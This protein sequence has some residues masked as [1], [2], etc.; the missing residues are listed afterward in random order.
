MADTTTTNLLLTK[1]EVGASTD[2]W[3]TKI[4]TDLDSVDAVFAA[5]GTGTSVGLNVGAGKTLAVA[6]TLTVTG[7]ASTIN[8]TAIGGT[9]PDTGAFT[10]LTSTG[11]SSFATS[12][13][14]VGIGA[15]ATG[16]SGFA[17]NK[18]FEITGASAPA[19]I[20]RPT[21]STSEHTVGGAG[22]GVFIG[23]TGAA[24]A[25]NNAIR[26]FTSNTNS[27]TTPTERA[28][29]D[30]SGNLLVGGTSNS[31]GARLLSE[32]ASGN[33]LGLRYTSIATWYNSIDSSGNYIWDKDG[34]EKAR[35]NSS[36]LMLVGTSSQL[37]NE[38][39]LS[40]LSVANTMSVKTTGGAGS[41]PILCWN[42]AA[43]G[44]IN[45]IN[46]F[47]GSSLTDGGTITTNGTVTTL[48]SPSDYRLKNITGALTTSGAFIDALKP[49]VGTYKSNG[50]AFVGFV[51]DQLQEV[52]PS[53][54]QGEK[55]AV[56]EKGNPVYQSLAYAS[57]EIITNLVAE[58]QSLRK[59]LAAAGI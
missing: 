15:S 47:Y 12:S 35:I 43:S 24:T 16:T 32:N 28:R 59:R 14:N 49:L 13:G 40:L 25:S 51:A 54:V 2:T 58:I 55:D 27:S 30:S 57:P 11:A 45:L 1:P 38:S 10:T 5:A 6:G 46:F 31:A 17:A 7:A 26:F 21:G 53:S 34:S 48:N 9:T 29:I 8:A 42:N 22:D 3:G 23:A 20:F 19:I 52:S 18:T 37:I 41:V 56:D 33:Q 36:G 50:S 4:N 39:T 44:T